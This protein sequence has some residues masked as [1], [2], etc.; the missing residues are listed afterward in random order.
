MN[1]FLSIV[2]K[3]ILVAAIPTVVVAL[4][5]QHKGAEGVPNASVTDLST[6]APVMATYTPA[7]VQPVYDSTPVSPTPASYATAS[8]GTSTGAELGGGTYTVKKGDTLFGIA[9][10]HYNDGKQWKKI[11]AANPGLSPQSL[12]VGQ[13]I[14][15]P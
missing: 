4:G 14:T 12:K 9:R 1:R 5:C 11:V 15:L 2:N 7:P 10:T 8:A 13:T 3:S 6:P